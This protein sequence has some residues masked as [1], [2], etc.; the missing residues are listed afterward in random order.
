MIE[1]GGE[2]QYGTSVRHGAFRMRG[3]RLR[4]ARHQGW[5]RHRL[6]RLEPGIRHGQHRDLGTEHADALYRPLDPSQFGRRR[7]ISRRL[8]LHLDLADQQDRSHLRLVTSEHSSRVFD[9]AGMCGGYPAPTC[10]M[11]RAVRN[12]NIHEL[13]E[14]QK[15]LPHAHRHRSRSSP[16]SRSSSRASMRRRK[17]PTSPRRTS[18]ATS[19]PMP[20]MAAAAM[21]M[22]WSA[23]PIKTACGCRERL[24]HPRSGRAGLRHRAQGGSETA[25]SNADLAATAKRRDADAREAARAGNAGVGWIEDG[26]RARGERPTSP[27]KCSKMYASAMKLSPRFTKDFASSGT[28]EAQLRPSSREQ[29][30]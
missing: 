27:P 21:A 19:S 7:K 15:P 9:N 28:L 1:M 24:S 10:Q 11:H 8:L 25:I 3:G 30:S 13:V 20:T 5:A 26:A 17:G 16:I 18:P 14:K 22:C 2:S 6:C 4:R 12:T 23:I 29:S